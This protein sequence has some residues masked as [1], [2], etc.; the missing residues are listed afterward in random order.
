MKIESLFEG[1]QN[2]APG[3]IGVDYEFAPTELIEVIYRQRWGRG[4]AS[5]AIMHIHVFYCKEVSV[6]IA[7]SSPGQ[8][9]VSWVEA[10]SSSKEEAVRLAVT[11]EANRAIHPDDEKDFGPWEGITLPPEYYRP[12]IGRF[13]APAEREADEAANGMLAASIPAKIAGIAAQLGRGGWS[14]DCLR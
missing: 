10:V 6:Y 3:E 9:G 13:Y 12:L 11:G 5:Q 14:F 8:F 1:I 2:P 4:A 7:S